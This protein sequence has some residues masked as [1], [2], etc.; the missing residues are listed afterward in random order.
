LGRQVSKWDLSPGNTEPRM[1]EVT[2]GTSGKIS[3]SGKIWK[4]EGQ[5][6]WEGYLVLKEALGQIDGPRRSYITP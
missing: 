5:S 3:K 4:N 1:R 2:T 6:L